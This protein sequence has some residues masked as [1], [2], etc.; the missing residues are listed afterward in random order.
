[1][2]ARYVSTFIAAATVIVLIMLSK[3]ALGAQRIVNTTALT[4]HL[5]VQAQTAC[6]TEMLNRIGAREV[7]SGKT[8]ALLGEIRGRMDGQ[9]RASISFPVA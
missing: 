4:S 9:F 5:N 2:R 3:P 7:L 8:Y 6:E 1:M